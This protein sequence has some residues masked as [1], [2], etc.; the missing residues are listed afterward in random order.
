MD[1]K[2]EVLLQVLEKMKPYWDMAPGII[3]SLRSEYCTDEMIE[4]ILHH[5]SNA[6]S[7]SS[8]QQIAFFIEGKRMEQKKIEAAEIEHDLADADLLLQSI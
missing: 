1:K 7:H 4:E 8:A 2:K 6:I 3:F 5:V